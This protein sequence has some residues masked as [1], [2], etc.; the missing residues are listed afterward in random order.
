MI[1]SRF[2]GRWSSNS[3][4]RYHTSSRWPESSPSTPSLSLPA[5]YSAIRSIL[6]YV[7]LSAHRQDGALLTVLELIASM[8]RTQFYLLFS[9][10][11][12]FQGHSSGERSESESSWRLCFF[13]PSLTM[14]TI[15]SWYTC[16][17]SCIVEPSSKSQLAPKP[18]LSWLYS[19]W[20]FPSCMP[21]PSWRSSS[22][23]FIL[24]SLLKKY[25]SLPSDICHYGMSDLLFGYAVICY[26]H[27]LNPFLAYAPTPCS[28]LVEWVFLL[29][30]L[31]SP[32]SICSLFTFLIPHSTSMFS[33]LCS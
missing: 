22:F 19:W 21:P 15:R 27:G 28:Y 10:H 32:S 13:P 26:H 31:S 23:Y 9:R 24:M 6:P 33:F 1:S 17:F 29:A 30:F 11:A 3:T 5:I 4:I 7:F 25:S 16:S 2:R 18:S 14:T 12:L 8:L 20:S